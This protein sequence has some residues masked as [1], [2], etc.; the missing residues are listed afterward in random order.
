M[1]NKLH[2]EPFKVLRVRLS[3]STATDVLE[4]VPAIFSST[5]AIVPVKCE[6]DGR[7]LELVLRC[8]TIALCHMAEIINVEAARGDAE[9]RRK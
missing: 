1:V 9:R 2:G 4:P 6:E 7:G 8:K 5:S 3:N